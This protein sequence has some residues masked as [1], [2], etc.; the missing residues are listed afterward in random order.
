MTTIYGVLRRPIITEKSAYQSSS[1]NQYAFEVAKAATKAQVKEAVEELFD[2]DVVKVNIMN[3][4]P[5][6]S[7][8][9]RSRRRVTRRSTY[10]KAVVTLAAGDVIDVFEGLG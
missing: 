1:L 2:V 3:V 5:K 9:G 4:P 8:R 10:K 7:V 6:R